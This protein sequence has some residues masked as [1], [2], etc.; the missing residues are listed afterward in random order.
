M[1][2]CL[3]EFNNCERACNGRSERWRGREVRERGRAT[4][5]VCCRFVGLTDCRNFGLS[6]FF[7]LS[8]LGH[9]LQGLGLDYNTLRTAETSR[10]NKYTPRSHVLVYWLL[11]SRFLPGHHHRGSFRH[12]VDYQYRARCPEDPSDSLGA[13]KEGRSHASDLLKREVEVRLTKY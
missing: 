2:A 9:P 1:T 6:V 12:S 7:L 4:Q 10:N 8:F 3:V 13:C 11:D 5:S